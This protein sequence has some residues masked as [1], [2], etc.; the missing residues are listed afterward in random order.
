MGGRKEGSEGESE[1]GREGRSG[2]GR[3]G[4]SEVGRELI[5]LVR[6]G[7]RERKGG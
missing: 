5:H 2:G 4:E 6:E 1:R 7:E 3:K